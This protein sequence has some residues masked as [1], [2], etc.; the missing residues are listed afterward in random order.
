MTN[1]VITGYDLRKCSCCGGLMLNM[2]DD[3]T[4]YAEGFYLID[5]P[6]PL[7]CPDSDQFPMRV[8]IRWEAS[9]KPV[10]G[11]NQRIKINEIACR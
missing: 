2:G 8:R 6:L 7:P 9:S 5:G 11:A 1:A 4:L 10:C 3:T